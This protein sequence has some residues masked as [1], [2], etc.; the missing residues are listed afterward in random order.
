MRSQGRTIGIVVALALLAGALVAAD[1]LAAVPT[2]VPAT[3]GAAAIGQPTSRL[4]RSAE[5]PEPVP[6]SSPKYRLPQNALLTLPAAIE[7]QMLTKRFGAGQ[8]PTGIQYFKSSA[9]LAGMFLLNGGSPQAKPLRFLTRGEWRFL[10]D[11]R[12]L[13]LDGNGNRLFLS[14][15]QAQV[16]NSAGL[17]LGSLQDPGLRRLYDALLKLTM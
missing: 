2:P 9:G 17:K 3:G 13:Q 10:P 5:D 11:R 14:A 12:F 8:G 16:L 6:D 7:L 15:G 1:L 4:A